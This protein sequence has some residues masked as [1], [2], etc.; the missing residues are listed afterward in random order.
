MTEKLS[1]QPISQLSALARYIDE[2]LE[3]AQQQRESIHLL[4]IEELDD[5]RLTG[6]IESVLIQQRSL[7]PV[8]EQLVRWQSVHLDAAQRAEVTRVRAQLAT[9][10]LVL[11]SILI[12]LYEMK[13][14]MIEHMLAH[15][16]AHIR[17]N[18]LMLKLA[19]PPSQD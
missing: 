11:N 17:F 12:V 18:A 16:D 2:A 4:P 5:T 10:Q 14:A 19:E 9:L 13:Q 8:E 1:W 3:R 15:P 6:I 7:M